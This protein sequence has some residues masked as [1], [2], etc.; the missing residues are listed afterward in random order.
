MKII[1]PKNENHLAITKKNIVPVE[2]IIKVDA[3]SNYSYIHLMSGEK[4]LVAKTLKKIASQLHH[5]SQ[6]IRINN[7][8]IINGQHATLEGDKYVL[9]NDTT[10][11]FSR[12]RL[13][14][15]QTQSRVS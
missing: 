1:L 8:T 2:S 7:S 6:F 13:R 5:H 14:H 9:N 12:R 15:F 4:I 3:Q 10:V 11:L